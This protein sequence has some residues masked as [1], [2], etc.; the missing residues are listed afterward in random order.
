MSVDITWLNGL[1]VIFPPLQQELEASTP[2]TS[3]FGKLWQ[4][5]VRF[6]YAA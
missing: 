2:K 4:N 1:I 5:K 3:A 6:T